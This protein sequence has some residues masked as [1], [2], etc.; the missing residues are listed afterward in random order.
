MEPTAAIDCIRSM[1]PKVVYPY[2]YDQVW[3]RPVPAG[4]TR[5]APTTRGLKELSDAL[6]GQKI[7]VRLADWYPK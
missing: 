6:N 7:A 2:H 5:P 1:N 3:V 4:G